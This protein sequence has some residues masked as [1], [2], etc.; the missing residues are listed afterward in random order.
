MDPTC[1]RCG[2]AVK[3]GETFCPHCGAPQFVVEAAEPGAQQVPVIRF[4]GDSHL[5]Q[6]RVAITSA[7]LVAIPVGLLSAL[8]EMYSLFVLMGGFAVIALYRRR[9]AGFTDG[10][11]GWRVGAILGIASALV[12]TATYATRMVIVRY[13]LHDGKA[14]DQLFQQATQMD[15]DYWMKASA[16]QGAQTPEFTHAMHTVTSFMLS[17][18][19]HAAMQLMTAAVMSLGMVLFAAVGGAIAGRLLAARTR[20]QR[21]L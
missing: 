1:H 10:K 21:S 16:Q 15:A 13:L 20:A 5:V 3:E 11:I 9:S 17:P 12:A 2:N 7:L 4:Q 19:G 18:D 14:I 6:W 8:T